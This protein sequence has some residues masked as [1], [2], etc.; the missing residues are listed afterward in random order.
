MKQF[1]FP[2]PLSKH[3]VYPPCTSLHSWSSFS[4]IVTACTYVYAYTYIFLPV[5]LLACMFSGMLSIWHWTVCWCLREDHLFYFYIFSLV[6]SNFHR[7]E[8]FRVF[9]CPL[10]QIY[11]FHPCSPAIWAVRLNIFKKYLLVILIF[12]VN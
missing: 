2:F 6:C 3:T 1:S 9:L 12:D 10:W 11:P 4:L 5:Q 7:V 8:A